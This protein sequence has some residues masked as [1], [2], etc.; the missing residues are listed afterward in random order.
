MCG[1]V[2]YLGDRGLVEVVKAE[3]G[4]AEAEMEAVVIED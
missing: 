3:K 1:F 2:G 4:V